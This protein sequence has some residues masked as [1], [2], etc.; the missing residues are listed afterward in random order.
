MQY[1]FESLKV[2]QGGMNLVKK[3]YKLTEK[4]PKEE[5]YGLVS[6]MKRAAVSIPSNIA[7]GKGKQYKKEYIQALYIAKG[8]LFEEMTLIHLSANLGYVSM[9]EKMEILASC[10]EVIAMLSGLIKVLK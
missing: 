4:L 9:D 10:S 8:S 5:L 1:D 6:Q 2:W 3:V 7:E